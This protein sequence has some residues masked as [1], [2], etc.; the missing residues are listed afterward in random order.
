[1]SRQSRCFSA[2]AAAVAVGLFLGCSKGDPAADAPA[3]I[4]H[5]YTVRGQV[6]VIPSTERPFDD[7]EIR[8]E[9]IP[10]YKLRNGEVNVN[11]KGFAGMVSMTMGFP[12]A[13]G[14]SLEGIEP[15]DKVEF[16]FITTW[17][18]KYPEYEVTEIRELPV[19][20]ELQFG[21]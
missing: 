7:L 14:V 8:H 17:G 13:E 5:T 6:V 3:P 18:E 11:S 19:D 16:V 21:G 4:Q 9:A 1:M 10:D 20:T 2:A 15:G 12:V